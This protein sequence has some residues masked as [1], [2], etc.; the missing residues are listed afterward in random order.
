[1]TDDERDNLGVKEQKSLAE[2]L[3]LAYTKPLS[4]QSRTRG[5]GSRSCP[6]STRVFGEDAFLSRTA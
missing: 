5:T 4:A 1:V 2:L 3:K 6:A